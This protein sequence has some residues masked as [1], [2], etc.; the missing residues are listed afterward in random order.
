MIRDYPAYEMRGV[1]FDIARIPT[2]ISFLNDY[3]KIMK[4]YKLN[5]MQLHINDN[6]WSDPAYSAKYEDWADTEASHRLESELFPSLA[7][8][9]SKFVKTGDSE[10]RY[11]YYYN[12]HTGKSGELYYTKEE[13]RKMNEEAKACG[14]QVVAELDTPGH[15]AAYTKYVHDHQEE[16]I[17][18]L[19]KYG[20]LK[21]ADYLNADGNVKQGASFYIHNPGNWELLALDDQSSNA[22]IRQNAINARIFM[23]AL[24]DEYLGGIDGIDAVFDAKMSTQVLMNT[25][26]E[27]M[28][29]KKLSAVT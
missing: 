9:K 5:E 14:I 18:S 2:R 3:T 26:T 21:A 25:G 15:S 11:D 20:Y 24:F 10:D 17:K 29:I 8:Q 4:W 12:V 16:V 28:Q 27:P 19:V 23:K 7:T 6:Q 13:F 1:M 22:Q